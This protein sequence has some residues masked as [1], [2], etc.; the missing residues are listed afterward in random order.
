MQI[1]PAR[2]NEV[3]QSDIVYEDEGAWKVL[4]NVRA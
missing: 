1:T 3:E 4:N 2:G